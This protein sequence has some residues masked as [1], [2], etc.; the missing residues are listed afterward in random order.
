MPNQTKQQVAEQLNKLSK[1][2]AT[3]QEIANYVAQTGYTEQDFNIDLN[4]IFR[5]FVA[6]TGATKI[7]PIAEQQRENQ[8]YYENLTASASVAK[9]TS[10]QESTTTFQQ[11]T[12]GGSTIVY[13]VPPTDTT[14]SLSY[15]QQADQTFALASAYQVNPESRFGRASLDRQLAEGK[16]TQS[17]YNQIINSTPDET[18]R[19]TFCS[20]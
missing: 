6:K 15:R 3:E 1:Q 14:L 11:S 18:I 2:G 20:I 7:S 17:Q 10:I 19:I 9:N 5:P 13:N 16:L 8:Q 4:G 12:G